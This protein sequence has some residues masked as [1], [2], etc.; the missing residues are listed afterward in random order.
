[1]C[2]PFNLERTEQPKTMKLHSGR[3]ASRVQVSYNPTTHSVY[4]LHRELICAQDGAISSSVQPENS[5]R[6]CVSLRTG[7]V[8]VFPGTPTQ[9]QSIGPSAATRGAGSG[10]A[11]PFSAWSW[12][13]CLLSGPPY[14]SHFLGGQSTFLLC[15]VRQ[16]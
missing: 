9:H 4:P 11:H 2:G 12:A 16:N 6:P 10:P 15:L 3:N 8:M 5:G 13:G 1:M 7:R 14:L